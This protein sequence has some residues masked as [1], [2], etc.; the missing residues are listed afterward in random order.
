MWRPCFTERSV[1]TLAR[2]QLVIKADVCRISVISWLVILVIH[3]CW[4]ANVHNVLLKPSK[5]LTTWYCPWFNSSAYSIAHNYVRNIRPS[6]S[7][8]VAMIKSQRVCRQGGEPRG[9][10]D[11]PPMMYIQCHS[12]FDAL[13][14]FLLFGVIPNVIQESSDALESVWQRTRMHRS[15]Y[16]VF[17]A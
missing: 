13:E 10:Y 17:N 1:V 16:V 3:A 7:M 5:T 9:W 14:R 15:L 11:P 8:S 2:H 12:C 4:L 6:A